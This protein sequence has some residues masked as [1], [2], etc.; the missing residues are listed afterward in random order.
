MQL[1]EESRQRHIALSQLGDERQIRF[2]NLLVLPRL[3]DE[4]V[5]ACQ[6]DEAL[7]AARHIGRERDS[8]H[9]ADRSQ[10][11][12]RSPPAQLDDLREKRGLLFI[13]HGADRPHLLHIGRRFVEQPRDEACRQLRSEGHFDAR[14]EAQFVAHFGRNRV[15]ECIVNS[16]W[17]RDLGKLGESLRHGGEGYSIGCDVAGH[18]DVPF[19]RSQNLARPGAS[20]ILP[21]LMDRTNRAA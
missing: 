7:A 15:G 4:R 17:N 13:Q 3:F 16:E 11:V 6:P 10:V 5:G 2:E 8:K 14:S 20:A 19:G 9:L 18:S 12:R 1:L 21:P